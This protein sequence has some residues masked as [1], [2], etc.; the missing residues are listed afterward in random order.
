MSTSWTNEGYDNE[1][2]NDLRAAY[3]HASKILRLN[4]TSPAPKRELLAQFTMRAAASGPREIAVIVP[5]AVAWFQQCATKELH[6]D[7][8]HLDSGTGTVKVVD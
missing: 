3:N 4:A 5:Q 8:T 7:V 2:L 6:R 1:A